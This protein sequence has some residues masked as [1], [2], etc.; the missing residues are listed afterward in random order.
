MP[1]FV[2]FDAPLRVVPVH[3]P[4]YLREAAPTLPAGGVLLTVP[5]AVSGSAQPMLWQA[6]EGMHF[7][8]AGAALKTPDARG[9]ARSGR[10]PRGR[11]AASW[12]T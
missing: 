5:F 11:P 1:V 12:P 3:T 4:A 6:V 2:T 8:L 7:R 10:A 9:A